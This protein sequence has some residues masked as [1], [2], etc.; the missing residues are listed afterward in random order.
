[1]NYQKKP[2]ADGF[3]IKDN[4]TFSRLVNT[5]TEQLSAVNLYGK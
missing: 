5:P 3:G 4:A 2:N 1:M